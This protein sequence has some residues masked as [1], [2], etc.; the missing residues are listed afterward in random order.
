VP[1]TDEFLRDFVRPVMR[2]AGYR[3]KHRRWWR[4][5]G[6][7]TAMAVFAPFHLGNLVDLLLRV[8]VTTDGYADFAAA[9]GWGWS[10]ET[11][12]LAAVR[13]PVPRTGRATGHW[14]VLV[15]DRQRWQRR[16]AELTAEL[17]DLV[18]PALDRLS[19]PGVLL[20]AVRDPQA[21][22][23][24]HVAALGAEV[25]L[26]V[27]R[28]PSAELAE[29]LPPA[30]ATHPYDRRLLE[31]ARTRVGADPGAPVDPS[32]PRGRLDALLTEELTP[33]LAPLDFV[34]TAGG[35]QRASAAGDLAVI[36]VTL[37]GTATPGRLAFH[38]YAGVL[39][40]PAVAYGIY[41]TRIS[42][43][44]PLDHRHARRARWS[45]CREPVLPA[46]PVPGP[47]TDL[48]MP[49]WTDRDLA[50]LTRALTGTAVPRIVRL[51]DR[52]ALLASVQQPDARAMLLAGRG[53][54]TELSEAL[55]LAGRF[56]RTLAGWV[57]EQH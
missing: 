19:D 5:R 8:G 12:F 7:V 28:G 55:A 57:A 3:W 39:P 34:R 46:D 56:D 49:P 45:W 38:V 32:S 14:P 41:L 30:G 16:G 51:L 10:N 15:E 52:D 18:L 17:T 13:P 23:S 36:D 44:W 50:E 22:Y 48:G 11:S 47:L 31:W 20:D 27:P 33:A 25:V 24:G 6:E 40:A 54:S 1:P 26:L 2:A 29:T 53:P 9:Q 21:R 43:D 37:S 4:S 35:Y 42:P